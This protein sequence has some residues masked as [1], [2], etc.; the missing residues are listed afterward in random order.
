MTKKMQL[1]RFIYFN[2]LYMFRAMFSRWCCVYAT[3]ASSNIGGHYQ[4]L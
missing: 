3:P 4:K 2:Q 1:F